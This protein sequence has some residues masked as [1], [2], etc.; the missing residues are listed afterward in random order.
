MREINE[1]I[2]KFNYTCTYGNGIH[3]RSSGTERENEASVTFQANGEV[4][5]LGASEGREIHSQDDRKSRC[6]VIRG[7]PCSMDRL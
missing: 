4:R 3:V 7:L 5:H 1:N 6:L 2:T